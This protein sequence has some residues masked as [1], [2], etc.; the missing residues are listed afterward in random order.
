LVGTPEGKRTVGIP[1]HR[2]EDNVRVYLREI[3]WK[4]VDWIHLAQDMDERWALVSTEMNL[5]VP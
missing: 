2:W 5:R 4:N 1:V 3:G